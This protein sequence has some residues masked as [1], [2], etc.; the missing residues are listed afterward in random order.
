MTGQNWLKDVTDSD[1]RQLW[2]RIE[3][4]TIM[5]DFRTQSLTFQSVPVFSFTH[6]SSL[7]WW[8][9]IGSITIHPL[10]E[11]HLTPTLVFLHFHSA[12]ACMKTSATS[13]RVVASSRLVVVIG[14]IEVKYRVHRYFFIYHSSGDPPILSQKPCWSMVTWSMGC[15]NKWQLSE[16]VLRLLL[17][18]RPRWWLVSDKCKRGQQ[19]WLL[20]RRIHGAA[21][22]GSYRWDDCDRVESVTFTIPRSRLSGIFYTASVLRCQILIISAIWCC[23]CCCSRPLRS[24]AAAAAA[25]GR[26]QCDNLHLYLWANMND[27]NIH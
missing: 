19:R 8:W 6:Y 20:F 10:P 14:F 27:N 5:I 21:V 4:S 1:R 9:W 11:I 7:W 24:T 23:F 18:V 16:L 22:P 26:G 2:T 13:R 3:L 12:A 25:A 15:H 17:F